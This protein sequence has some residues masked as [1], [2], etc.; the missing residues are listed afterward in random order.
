[1]LWVECG[2]IHTDLRG[3]FDYASLNTSELDRASRFSILIMS[4]QDG[5]LVREAKPPQ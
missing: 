3:K 4:D 5:A 1:M 2:L